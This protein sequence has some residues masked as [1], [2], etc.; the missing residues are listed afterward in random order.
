[1]VKWRGQKVMK[2]SSYE[3]KVPPMETI[4]LMHKQIKEQCLCYV[5]KQKY[6][7]LCFT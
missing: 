7:T 6:S 5:E 3:N 4:N 1:M 2:I